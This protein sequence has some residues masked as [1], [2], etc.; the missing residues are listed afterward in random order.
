VM[1]CSFA[2]MSP[3]ILLSSAILSSDAMCFGGLSCCYVLKKKR[4][5]L[6]SEETMDT[7]VR[8]KCIQRLV[9]EALTVSAGIG[10]LRTVRWLCCTKIVGD[11]F[12]AMRAAAASRH[13][14]VLRFFL[15]NMMQRHVL[16]FEAWHLRT[17]AWCP[18]VV[19]DGAASFQTGCLGS[20]EQAQLEKR[21]GP[22]RSQQERLRRKLE[23]LRDAET[24]VRPEAT[25]LHIEFEPWGERQ[26]QLNLLDDPGDAPLLFLGAV[27]VAHA[28]C[29][30]LLRPFLVKLLGACG[31]RTRY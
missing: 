6:K 17:F 5:L 7:D 18:F 8:R 16:R 11:Q 19:V 27:A 3:T 29:R 4:A 14:E 22:S 30:R 10:D 9:D 24:T 23:C 2:E 25:V 1:K 13:H 21:D 28:L 31:S 15:E 12:P 26:S 20:K